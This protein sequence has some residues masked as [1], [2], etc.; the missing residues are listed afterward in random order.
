MFQL[1]KHLTP[2]S[3]LPEKN[4][5]RNAQMQSDASNAVVMQIMQTQW[6]CKWMQVMQWQC[7]DNATEALNGQVSMLFLLLVLEL[8]RFGLLL[9]PEQKRCLLFKQ[10][11]IIILSAPE[12]TI[13]YCNACSGID[14]EYEIVCSGIDNEY[15]IVCSGT[16]NLIFKRCQFQNKHCLF[17]N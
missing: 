12:Q 17:R 3:S 14:N 5:N 2:K 11:L 13:F 10:H 16:K 6:Q 15:K 4:A 1:S 7:K 9:V 8:T